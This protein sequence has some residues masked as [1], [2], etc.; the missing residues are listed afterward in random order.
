MP[1]LGFAKGVK[2]NPECSL[3]I[4]EMEVQFPARQSCPVMLL[5]E[6]PRSLLPCA[7]CL[8][9]YWIQM[10]TSRLPSPARAPL[11]VPLTPHSPA[12]TEAI[13]LL[14]GKQELPVILWVKGEKDKPNMP[15]YAWKGQNLRILTSYAATYLKME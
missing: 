13:P 15:I 4:V 14:E 7:P 3:S 11:R 12:G 5:N 1:E 2:I 9:I 10:R 8:G 6:T